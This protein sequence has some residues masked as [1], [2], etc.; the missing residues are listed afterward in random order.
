MKYFHK[1]YLPSH[2]DIVL[3]QCYNKAIISI[4]MTPGRIILLF[5]IDKHPRTH[6]HSK[7]CINV[8]K[9]YPVP[10][11]VCVQMKRNR[12]KFFHQAL[13]HRLSSFE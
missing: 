9:T 11:P 13:C 6:Y 7:T 4:E 8:G 5:R 3:K 12:N 2:L 10:K 1:K